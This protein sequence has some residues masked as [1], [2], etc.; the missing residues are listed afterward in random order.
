M[1]GLENVTR[2]FD[3][4]NSSWWKMERV[5]EI[6]EGSDFCPKFFAIF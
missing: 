4:E 5:M 1:V 3:V 6:G 2:G